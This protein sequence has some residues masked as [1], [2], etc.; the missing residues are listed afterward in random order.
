[1]DLAVARPRLGPRPQAAGKLRCVIIGMANPFGVVVP[2]NQA[3]TI[4]RHQ[5]RQVLVDA[6]AVQA[7]VEVLLKIFQLQFITL[8]STLWRVLANLKVG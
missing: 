8:R 6:R 7:L 2:S 1:M 4:D 5:P 3:A